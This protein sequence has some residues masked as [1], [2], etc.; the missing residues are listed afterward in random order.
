M[1]SHIRG[2]DSRMRY[3]FDENDV[4]RLYQFMYG[5]MKSTAKDPQGRRD[6]LEW[7]MGGSFR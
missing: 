3:T 1:E 5:A 6:D 7:F 2:F 4:R